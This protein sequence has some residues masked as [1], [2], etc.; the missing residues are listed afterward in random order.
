MSATTCI[1]RH[2]GAP[3]LCR[4]F[5]VKPTLELEA[6][7]PLPER[8]TFTDS[9]APSI[10]PECTVVHVTA[11][12]PSKAADVAMAELL[13]RVAEETRALR[14]AEPTLIRY[15]TTVSAHLSDTMVSAAL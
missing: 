8:L 2:A 13:A 7:A 4:T 5:E 6:S 15:A 10:C 11:G 9:G 12:R 3:Y 14:D 1:I